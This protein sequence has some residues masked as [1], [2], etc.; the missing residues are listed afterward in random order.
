ML[1]D[2]RRTLMGWIWPPPPI[3]G[4]LWIAV[5]GAAGYSAIVWVLHPTDGLLQ[6]VWSSQFTLLNTA[7]LGLLV[8]FRTKIAYDRWWEG[9]MLWGALV[10]NSRNLCLKAREL[11]KPDAAERRALAGLVTG[12][13]A[14][15]MRHLR[16]PLKLSEVSGFEKEAAKPEHVPAYLAGQLMATVAGWRANGRIDGHMHQM[17]DTNLSSLMDVCGACERIRNTPLVPSYLSLLRHGLVLGFL[18]TP[19]A[20]VQSLDAWVIVVLPVA[21]YFLFGIE[22]TAEAV[23]QPFGFDGDDLALETYCETIRKSAN[24]ILNR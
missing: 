18:A 7:I 15:L 4:R 13:A 1:A 11:A 20:L 9:R 14:A 19:W 24:D 5:A 16:G 22:L 23:E 8:S 3:A 21:V 6:P 10:N 2:N 17:L 12:F